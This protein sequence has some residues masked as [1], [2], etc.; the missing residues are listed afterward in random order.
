MGAAAVPI[1]LAVASAG[2]TAYNQRK[3]A[4]KQDQAAYEGLLEQQKIQQRAN[5]RMAESLA[6][7]E[8]S[9]QSAAAIQAERTSTVRDQLRKKQAIG[10]GVLQATGGGDAV[11]EAVEEAQTGAV[12]YGDFINNVLA[13]IDTPGL[14]RQEEAF[15]RAD[16]Q[17]FLNY[18]RRNSAQTDALTRARMATIR[19][20]PWLTMLAAGLS[21]AASG[22]A[23]G[24]GNGNTMAGSAIQ[25]M[26][27]QAAYS[28][29]A[30]ATL[31]PGSPM[32]VPPQGFGIFNSG[33][34]GV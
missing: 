7:L 25:A 5:A 23:G 3:T 4:K 14:Q 19:D 29:T 6:N 26:P 18:L 2:V 16:S 11:T 1:A 12:D 17:S 8:R 22:T 24:F 30:G 21:G 20:N 28:S 13:A 9:P 27:P 34:P 31:F 10:L 15:D 33:I 32:T